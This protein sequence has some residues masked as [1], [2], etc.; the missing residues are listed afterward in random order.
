MHA[1]LQCQG[2]RFDSS[3]Q[4]ESLS[5][6]EDVCQCRQSSQLHRPC[7]K[8][9]Y[10]P[11]YVPRT[12]LESSCYPHA[13]ASL[14]YP[15]NHQNRYH[16]S[17]QAALNKV[18]NNGGYKKMLTPTSSDERKR[19]KKRIATEDRIL[20]RT[21]SNIDYSASLPDQSQ[22]SF[23]ANSFSQSTGSYH[24]RAIE[25]AHLDRIS[26]PQYSNLSPH[27]EISSS[28]L[29]LLESDINQLSS[30]QRITDVIT[31]GSILKVRQKIVSPCD[32]LL[33]ST[34]AS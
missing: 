20:M 12:M 28:D 27:Q 13:I 16:R 29:K 10:G 4:I 7:Y 25:D 30:S 32:C 31:P 6:G 18:E 21:A 14:Q 5:Y 9:D 17:N 24:Y 3:P 2:Q 22:G 8:A 15:Q 19:V 1:S 23:R 33:S 26:T 34:Y 11:G